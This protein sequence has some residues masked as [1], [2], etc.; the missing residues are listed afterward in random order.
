MDGS[1]NE[2]F[3]QDEMLRIGRDK[4]RDG[5]QKRVFYLRSGGAQKTN[6]SDK[7]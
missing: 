3:F 2:Q 7:R 1:Q 6:E 4:S 5:S